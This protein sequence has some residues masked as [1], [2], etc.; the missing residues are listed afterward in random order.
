MIFRCAPRLVLKEWNI[1]FCFSLLHRSESTIFTISTISTIII[2]IIIISIQQQL[3]Q[4]IHQILLYN[5]QFIHIFPRHHGEPSPPSA[6]S[7][8]HGKEGTFGTLCFSTIF[9][10]IF[11]ILVF[12][13]GRNDQIIK[14]SLYLCCGLLMGCIIPNI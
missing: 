2:I 4:H 8:K 13:K 5:L 9:V 6:S 7:S 1:T 3:H 10:N 14:L 11:P 12:P